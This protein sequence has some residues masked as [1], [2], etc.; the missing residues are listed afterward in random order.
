L[1]YA[2]TETGIYVSFDD[3]LNWQSL[4]LNL[5]VVPI[6]DLVIHKR[7]MDL[8]A[9]T[10]GRA[11]WILDD[12]AVLHQMAD[13]AR[14]SA[15]FLLKPED[16][17]RM[18]AGGSSLPE[19][20]TI[21]RNP[22]NGVVV[23]YYLKNKP[24][25]QITL[26][27]TDP[28]G[29]T[30]RKLTSKPIEKSNPS[31]AGGAQAPTAME[32]SPEPAGE[33]SEGGGRRGGE[34]R[35]PAEQGMNRFV[36]DM[37]EAGATTFPGMILWGGELRG[38]IVMPG[39][40]TVKLTVDGATQAQSFEVKKDPRVSTRPEEFMAQHKFLVSVRDRLT[41]THNAILQIRTV[42]SQVDDLLKR[43]KDDQ[44]AKPVID[45]GM[46]LNTRLTAI[47]EALYQT[48]NRSSQDPLNYPIRL[49]NKLAELGSVAGS[50]DGA[51]TAQSLVV[52][53]RLMIAITAELE[54]LK[55]LMDADLPAFNRLVRDQNV[56]AVIVKPSAQRT[57]VK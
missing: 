34:P 16:A 47:E 42:R 45:A 9:A 13:A 49:D 31:Q 15:A 23:Y 20:A 21:G 40:H 19:T 5:P 22:S 52:Y 46:A 36:W 24:S 6:A 38:P 1:L 53:D 14:T 32:P 27:F 44:N 56:P 4:Q 51:P 50:A 25:S 3:G 43:L 26:E 8:V 12:L 17:Y 28:A 7:E 11:F 2:G 30:I 57:S 41:D 35:I 39:S 55:V 54:K 10:Q 37:R 33:E 29:K 48:K 18:Q